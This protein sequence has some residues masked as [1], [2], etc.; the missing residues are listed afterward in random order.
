M[1]L[2]SLYHAAAGEAAST[3][4]YLAQSLDQ[5]VFMSRKVIPLDP[6]WDKLRGQPEFEALMKES[7]AKQ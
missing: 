2:L 6:W 5:T 3:A 4:G 1:R 7:E